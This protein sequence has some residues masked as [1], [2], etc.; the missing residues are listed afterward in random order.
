MPP[1]ARKSGVLEK[2]RKHQSIEWTHAMIAVSR[3]RLRTEFAHFKSSNLCLLHDRPSW[4]SSFSGRDF[5]TYAPDI[6]K[7]AVDALRH[8]G[9]FP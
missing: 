1:S 2:R 6:L 9:I 7:S 3:P 5:A 8:W 4:Y